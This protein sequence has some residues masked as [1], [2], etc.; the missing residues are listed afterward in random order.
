VGASVQGTE[1]QP[2]PIR[3]ATFNGGDFDLK[4]VT[5]GD[6]ETV[7]STP[8]PQRGAE[9]IVIELQRPS[10][11]TGAALST[12]PPLE[13]Y[14]RSLAI[15]TS[16]DGKTWEDA[17]TGGMAGPVVEGV[18]R[19]PRTAEGRINFRPETALFIRMRQLGTHPD[20][21]WFIAELKVYGAP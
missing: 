1:G 12:G 10:R 13:G 15:A 6:P 8:K 5:D 21:G 2:L 14:P 4:A 3:G 18:L 19:D 17:W 16:I 9:E 20:Y 11:V 7:W